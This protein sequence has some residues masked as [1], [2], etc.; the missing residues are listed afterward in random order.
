MEKTY[1]DENGV[2]WLNFDDD[3]VTKYFDKAKAEILADIENGTLPKNVSSYFEMNDFVDANCYG[4]FCE[5]N[6]ISS[7]N[8]DFERKVQEAVENW[9]K[10]REI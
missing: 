3:L 6:Y 7:E 8:F 1:F 4:G 2:E 9:L 5:E 10:T